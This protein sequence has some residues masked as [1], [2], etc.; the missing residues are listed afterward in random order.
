MYA[1]EIRLPEVFPSQEVKGHTSAGFFRSQIV[2]C[3]QNESTST[4]AQTSCKNDYS[5]PFSLL[6]EESEIDGMVTGKE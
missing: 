4:K 3:S 2:L 5:Y 1:K 6:R